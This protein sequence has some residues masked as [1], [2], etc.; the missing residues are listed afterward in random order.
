M[1][2]RYR[3]GA[4]GGIGEGGHRKQTDNRHRN[5]V[6]GDISPTVL[7]H[8]SRNTAFNNLLYISKC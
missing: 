3:Q 6:R 8:G 1:Q 7:Q 2:N 4:R 5:S